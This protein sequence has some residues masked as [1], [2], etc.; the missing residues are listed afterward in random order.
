MGL[1]RAHPRRA[2]WEEEVRLPQLASKKHCCSLWCA[3]TS[4][5]SPVHIRRHAAVSLGSG[6]SCP[7]KGCRTVERHLNLVAYPCSSCLSQTN[8]VMCL[9]HTH[10]HL[11]RYAT[12]KPANVYSLCSGSPGFPPA[13]LIKPIYMS[14]WPHL[15][16][17]GGVRAS[18][19]TH[20]PMYIPSQGTFPGLSSA[21]ETE[22]I[23]LELV[24]W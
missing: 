15:F 14:K 7:E 16:D 1:C 20:F 4:Q 5:E 12:P 17:V 13:N 2:R 9:T 3:E 11:H 6:R 23:K 22:I 18:A 24:L 19:R 21:G 10:I 8:K